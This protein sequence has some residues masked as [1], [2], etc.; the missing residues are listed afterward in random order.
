M[1]PKRMTS[2]GLASL[3]GVSTATVSRAFSDDSS[4]NSG[5]RTRILELAREHKYQPNAIARSLNKSQ[6]GLVSIVVNAIGNPNEAELLEELVPR[7]QKIHKVP[8]LVSCSSAEDRHRLVQI[9]STYQ[10]DHAVV[11]SDLISLESAQSI[12]YNIQPIISTSE[13]VLNP[14][15]WSIQ[16][17]GTNAAQTIVNRLVGKGR[18]RF[19]YLHGRTTSWIDKQRQGWFASALAEKGLSFMGGATGDYTYESGYKEAVMLL[20]RHQLDTVICGNDE[21]AIGVM[22][23]ARNTLGLRVPEDIAIVGNDGL[24]LARWE[25]HDLTTIKCDVKEVAEKVIEMILMQSRGES[26]MSY[27]Q[28]ASV[29]WGATS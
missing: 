6:T 23:A 4:I 22:D 14:D 1:R 25:C 24:D 10:V 11:F 9:A 29:V 12:F 21:M 13:P 27:R 7:L 3:A 16:L 19:G 2:K 5:T 26:P 28:D 18:H 17:D 8:L 20:R 15:I